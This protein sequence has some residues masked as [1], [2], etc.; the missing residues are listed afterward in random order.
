MPRLGKTYVPSE[1][2]EQAKIMLVGEA[3][4]VDEE[5]QRRP[6]IGASGELLMRYLG[7]QRIFRHEVFLTNLCKYRPEKNKFQNALDSAELESG[8]EELKEEIER[9]QPNVIIALGNW[10][11]YFLTGQCG[12]K[13]NKP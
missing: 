4:G 1:G 12:T 10:P 5:R 7:R 11:L 3:P 9:V 13:N 6:F 8:L 2:N